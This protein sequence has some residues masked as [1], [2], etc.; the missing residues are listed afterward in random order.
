[1]SHV[2]AQIRE[3]VRA[4]LTSIDGLHES[5]IVDSDKLPDDF[6]AE[7]VLVELGGE[8]IQQIGLGGA[9]G[10]KNSR[11]LELLT[12]VYALDKFETLQNAEAIA[13]A[14]EA[15]LTLDPRMGGLTKN[16]SLRA[17]LIEKNR[18]G[19]K[20][21]ARLRLQWAVTYFTNE[22]DATIPA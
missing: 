2:R 13:A 20:P 21:I 6:H 14:I 3:Y 8:T 10:R 18:D 7:F 16:L 19:K 4:L 17:Y 1:M 15:K 9:A 22:R 11:E 12:D 5:V